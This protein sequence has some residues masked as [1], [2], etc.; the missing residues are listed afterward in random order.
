MFH[1]SISILCVTRLYC[2][3]LLIYVYLAGIYQQILS[4]VKQ[5]GSNVVKNNHLIK[6][7]KYVCLHE[8]VSDSYF[9]IY[10]HNSLFLLNPYRLEEQTFFWLRL[11]TLAHPHIQVTDSIMLNWLS[12]ANMT[13]SMFAKVWWFVPCSLERLCHLGQSRTVQSLLALLHLKIQL[14][15]RYCS[16][17]ANTSLV[18]SSLLGLSLHSYLRQHD[19]NMSDLLHLHDLT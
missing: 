6:C 17:S 16:D 14:V 18:S 4:K 3:C 7:Q 12:S 11:A 2:V 10:K 15:R 9:S 19:T 5:S 1:N 13:M 8:K